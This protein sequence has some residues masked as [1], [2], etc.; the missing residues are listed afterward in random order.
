MA[1]AA[2][3][4]YVPAPAPVRRYRPQPVAASAVVLVGLLITVALPWTFPAGGGP[5]AVD[6]AITD[7]VHDG[8]DAHAGAYDLL[9]I[10]SDAY[11]VLPLLLIGVL[12]C[13]CRRDWWGAGF[14][15]V[16]PELVVAINTWALK[17]LWGRHLDDYLAYPSGHT[18]QMIAIATALALVAAAAWLR[19]IVAVLATVAL[20]AV[21]VGMFGLGYHYPTDVLGG[22]VFAAAAVTACWMALTPL[23]AR[24]DHPAHA[25]QE[26]GSGR[27]E[28]PRAD[29]AEQRD[30]EPQ[31]PGESDQHAHCEQNP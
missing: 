14:L 17:P 10:P 24:Y 29:G 11:V 28:S 16:V 15:V 27:P 3:V 31:D 2:R 19:L 26:D 5:T 13:A 1:G 22:T 9:V 8:L 21:A 7:R 25:A 4:G 20:A 12:W 30:H 18:V 23:W 6:R